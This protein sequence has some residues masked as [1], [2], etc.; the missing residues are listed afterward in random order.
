MRCSIGSRFQEGMILT[1]STSRFPDEL[2]KFKIVSIKLE[3][4]D[5]WWCFA[6]LCEREDMSRA[7]YLEDVFGKN[8]IVEGIE[9]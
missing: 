7:W 4:R 3:R 5:S 6:Y 2:E 1:I 9:Q 8:Y